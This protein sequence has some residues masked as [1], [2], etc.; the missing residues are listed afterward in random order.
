MFSRVVLQSWA[1]A[2]VAL[3]QA[4]AVAGWALACGMGA[5][6]YPYLRLRTPLL[7]LHVSTLRLRPHAP[8]PIGYEMHRPNLHLVQPDAAHRADLH[9]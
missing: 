9:H 3:W 6:R 8:R 1:A 7:T 4:G 2:W 5:P